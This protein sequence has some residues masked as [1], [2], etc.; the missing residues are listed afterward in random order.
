MP[1]CSSPSSSSPSVSSG[2]SLS[3]IR[4]DKGERHQLR[5]MK[6]PVVGYTR[7]ACA[8]PVQSEFSGDAVRLYVIHPE[9]VGQLAVMTGSPSR[10]L[11]VSQNRDVRI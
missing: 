6:L 9:T 7:Y 8:V 1:D 5:K 2:E 4:D 10:G 11:V 3:Y